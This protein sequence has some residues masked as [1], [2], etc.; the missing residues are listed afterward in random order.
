MTRDWKTLHLLGGPV[1]FL[2]LLVL[3]SALLEYPVRGSLGLL[4]WMS[5]WWISSR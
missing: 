3:P 4:V 5:W 2:L 1:A